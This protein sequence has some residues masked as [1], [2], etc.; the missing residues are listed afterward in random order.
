MDQIIKPKLA[1]IVIPVVIKSL[2]ELLRAH[3]SA[4]GKLKKDYQLLVVNQMRLN[5]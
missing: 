2:N 1:K 5:K 3:W 4:K